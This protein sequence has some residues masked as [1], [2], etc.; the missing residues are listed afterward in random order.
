MA[1][2]I[3]NS[4]QWTQLMGRRQRPS[5]LT[6]LC[7]NSCFT[8]ISTWICFQSPVSCSAR[9]IRT[10]RS[11][12][13][14]D[15]ETLWGRK[16]NVVQCLILGMDVTR[17]RRAAAAQLSWVDS[18]SCSCCFGETQV[19]PSAQGASLPGARQ[20]PH[21]RSSVGKSDLCGGSECF[22]SRVRASVI[23]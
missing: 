17:C 12:F 16:R 21:N 3:Y 2:Y 1:G 19:T 20:L 22:N 14:A 4:A 5:V 9:W 7:Q 13:W 18:L 6:T 15:F 23:V 10:S 11:F 8:N